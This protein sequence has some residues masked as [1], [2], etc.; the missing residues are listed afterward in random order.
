MA[1]EITVL[2]QS[3]QE[4]LPLREPQPEP[5][6]VGSLSKNLEV[7]SISGSESDSDTDSEDELESVS[8]AGS[9]SDDEVEASKE[10]LN[11][12]PVLVQAGFMK[13]LVQEFLQNEFVHEEDVLEDSDIRDLNEEIVVVDPLKEEKIE[14]FE[15]HE[16]PEATNEPEITPKQNYSKMAVSEL[17]DI[18][19]D[20]NI[21]S[22]EKA[23]KLKKKEL[24]QLL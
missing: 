6:A 19:V 1:T 16:L 5:V 17:I 18:V 20:K 14:F 13:E 24:L 3:K 22:K 2:K 12:D 4:E 8:D 9:D 11:I 15:I 10:A 7:Y 23:K 21:L